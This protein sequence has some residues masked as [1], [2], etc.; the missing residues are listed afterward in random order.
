MKHLGLRFPHRHHGFQR[1]KALLTALFTI[2]KE[3]EHVITLLGA[4]SETANRDWLLP[5]LCQ[6]LCFWYDGIK[7]IGSERPT[8]GQEEGL[9]TLHSI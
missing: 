2:N 8:V 5:K 7:G 6:F 1:I 3:E 9:I 4:P